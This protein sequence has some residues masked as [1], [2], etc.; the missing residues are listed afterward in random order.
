MFV[1]STV[2]PLKVNATGDDVSAT[3]MIGRVIRPL[4]SVDPSQTEYQGLI[5]VTEEGWCRDGVKLVYLTL[6]A[7][8]FTRFRILWS[9]LTS[10]IIQKTV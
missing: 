3:V 8:Y 7:P 4:R 6:K 9:S 5:E 1:T 10:L 2:F